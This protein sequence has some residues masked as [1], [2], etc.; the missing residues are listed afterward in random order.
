MKTVEFINGLNIKSGFYLLEPRALYDQA[1]IATTTEGAPIY[2]ADK[3]FVLLTEKTDP[4]TDD[5]AMNHFQFNILRECEYLP[6]ESR[7]Y[8]K[9]LDDEELF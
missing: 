4:L 8:F 6:R 3:I 2:C 9:Y 1:I 7:P 5:Q